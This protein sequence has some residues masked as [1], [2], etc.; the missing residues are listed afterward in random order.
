MDQ[1]SVPDSTAWPFPFPRQ[2][3]EQTPPAV[4][5][6]LLAVQQDLAQLRDLHN[7]VDVLE[8]RLNQDAPTGHRRRI[9]RPR[10]RFGTQRLPRPARSTGRDL[11]QRATD[12]TDLLRCRAAGALELGSASEDPR[13]GDAGD[14]TAL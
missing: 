7:R 14:R 13:P 9:L 10:S 3:W 12:G 8:A 1:P 11:W 4:Q 6:Y 2:D 5:A